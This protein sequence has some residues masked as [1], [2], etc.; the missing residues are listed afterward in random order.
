MAEKLTEA[1]LRKALR[2]ILQDFHVGANADWVI[3]QWRDA[4]LLDHIAV[5]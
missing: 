5:E 3:G 2:E 1:E 4:G